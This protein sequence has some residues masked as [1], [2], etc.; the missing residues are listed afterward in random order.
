MVN[1][2]P[3]NTCGIIFTEGELFIFFIKQGS[4]AILKIRIGG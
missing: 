4:T 3:L 2:I 1:M